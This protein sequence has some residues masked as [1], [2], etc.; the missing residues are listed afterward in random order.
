MGE[1][2][3]F[4]TRGNGLATFHLQDWLTLK[5]EFNFIRPILKSTQYT[6]NMHKGSTRLSE[7]YH[8]LFEISR[9]CVGTRKHKK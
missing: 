7:Y 6:K 8:L 4:Y 9:Y 5:N 2:I 1:D 3:L